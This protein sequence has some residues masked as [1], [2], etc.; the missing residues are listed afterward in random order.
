MDVHGFLSYDGSTPD[1]CMIVSPWHKLE[2]LG[3]WRFTLYPTGTKNNSG[4]VSAVVT[5]QPGEQVLSNDNEAWQLR[6]LCEANA[7]RKGECK[8]EEEEKE[9]K[10]NEGDAC[11]AVLDAQ[12]LKAPLDKVISMQ[13]VIEQKEEYLRWD[14]D[15]DDD[16]TLRIRVLFRTCEPSGP[17]TFVAKETMDKCLKDVEGGLSAIRDTL[18]TIDKPQLVDAVQAATSWKSCMNQLEE[19]FKMQMD[20]LASLGSELEYQDRIDVLNRK[21]AALK[22]EEEVCAGKGCPAEELNAKEQE[23][24]S[25]LKR[26]MLMQ[27]TGCEGNTK[28]DAGK[29]GEKKNKEELPQPPKE[30]PKPSVSAEEVMRRN[31]ALV[32]SLYTVVEQCERVGALSNTLCQI[33]DGLVHYIAQVEQ[34]ITEQTQKHEEFVQKEKELEDQC[35]EAQRKNQILRGDDAVLKTLT[36]EEVT[37]YVDYVMDAVG[38]VAVQKYL[39][40]EK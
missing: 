35:K 33:R 11:I 30:L 14:R 24:R 6:V 2:G 18:A 16:D 37:K 1:S 13:K 32:E 25:T 17:K 38:Q 27:T 4:F 9:K 31:S 39:T 5:F 36:M 40:K 21:L 29:D 19:A 26:L 8:E 12:H 15:F 20:I 22:E 34:W 7:I 23:M 10:D 28:P 3:R